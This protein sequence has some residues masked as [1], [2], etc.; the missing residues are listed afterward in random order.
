MYSKYAQYVLN[1]IREDR[2]KSNIQA[3][4]NYTISGRHS[5]KELI[6]LLEKEP[7]AIGFRVGWMLETM[8]STHPEYLL[9]I[10]NALFDVR[11]DVK[12]PGFHRSIGKILA[13]CG[14]PDKD[15][16]LIVDTL[17]KWLQSSETDVAVKVH[18]MTALSSVCRRYAE[19]IHELKES[20][21][22]QMQIESIAFQSRGK[23]VLKTLEALQKK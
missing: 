14:I 20:I 3:L 10:R 19:L 1:A 17:F 11:N 8:S 21:E 7:A 6:P 16:G 5:V 12:H 18:A 13:N 23:K 2:S 4:V 9:N 22:S 15:E